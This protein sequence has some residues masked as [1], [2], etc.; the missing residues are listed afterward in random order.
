MRPCRRE[1]QFKIQNKVEPITYWTISFR[2]SRKMSPSPFLS[3]TKVFG[4]SPRRLMP[5]MT[6]CLLVLLCLMA[7]IFSYSLLSTLASLRIYD[8]ARIHNKLWGWGGKRIFVLSHEMSATGAPRVCV[9][10][11]LLVSDM[12]ARVTLSVPPGVFGTETALAAAAADFGPGTNKLSFDISGNIEIAA[13]SD[14]LIVSTADPRQSAWIERFRGAYPQFSA[15]VWWVHEG[16][17]VMSVFPPYATQHAIELMTTHGMVNEVVFPS[18]ATCTWWRSEMSRLMPSSA[19]LITALGSA[20]SVYWGLPQWREDLFHAAARDIK[21][22]SELRTGQGFS[23]SDFV[24]LV[25]A[26]Y[27]PIKGH[28]GISHAFN[29]ARAMCGHKQRLR[30]VAA[31]SGFG[32]NGLFPPS[33][34]DWVRTD[35]DMR[36][37][38]PTKRVAEHIAAADAFISNTKAG[39]ETWGLAT[40]EALA[41]G[42]PVLSSRVGGALEQ[43]TH[44]V[45]A[46]LHDVS[47][48][49]R[50]QDDDA[51]EV[52]QLAANMC[53]IATDSAL[54]QR[55]AN[56]GSSFVSRQLGQTHLELSLSSTFFHLFSMQ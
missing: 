52:S 22:R 43:L 42:R 51:S 9:E 34:L 12:G 47:R 49:T 19:S 36:F 4:R 28:T 16:P 20:R 31:G 33:E 48:V 50:V 24:F 32:V 11:A 26:S 41:S 25:L 30:L 7:A 56:E 3:E 10:F 40:L 8:I 29:A 46:L 5:K 38:G 27:H 44:N 18:V 37:E 45:T 54:R 53:A 17:S 21:A 2:F 15:L 1:D 39:G 14:L 55:L 23:E 35:P 6:S 13:A